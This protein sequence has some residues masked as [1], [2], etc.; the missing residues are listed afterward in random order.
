[1]DVSEA[2]KVKM[3]EDENA[4]LKKLLAEA[5]LDNAMPKDLNEKNADAH[6]QTGSR[7]SSHPE[8]RVKPAAGVQDQRGGPYSD[9]Y[10]NIMPLVES[11]N[12]RLR[13]ELLN[14]TR[15]TSLVHSRAI[16]AAWDYNTSRSNSRLGWL[17][18]F[19]FANHRDPRKQRPLGAVQL[20]AAS[21]RPWPLHQLPTRQS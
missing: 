14:E 10:R 1:M 2:R 17:T 7:G 16:L 20:G 5:M 21:P 15:F 9:P 13:D 19:E 8:L 3:P 4:K 6:G 12:G 18:P 11:F